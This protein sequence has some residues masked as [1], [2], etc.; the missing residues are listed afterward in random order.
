MRL[1]LVLVG[2]DVFIVGVAVVGFAT[3]FAVLLLLLFVV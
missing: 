1:V 3:H 2:F